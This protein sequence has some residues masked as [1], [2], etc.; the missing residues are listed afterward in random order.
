[1]DI[2]HLPKHFRVVVLYIL[3]AGLCVLITDYAVSKLTENPDWIMTLEQ[4]KGLAFIAM[5][6]IL[7]YFDRKHADET[8]KKAEE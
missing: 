6:A 5:T 7:L 2:L 1:M 4:Y 8:Q 3:V